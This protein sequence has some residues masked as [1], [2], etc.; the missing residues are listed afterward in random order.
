MSKRLEQMLHKGRHMDCNK[1]T[2][3][4]SSSLGMSLGKYKFTVSVHA[5]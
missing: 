4:C 3:M 5:K 1:Q 2:K